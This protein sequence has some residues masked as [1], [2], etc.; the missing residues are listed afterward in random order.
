MLLPR[1]QR[2]QQTRVLKWAHWPTLL[3][4][5]FLAQIQGPNGLG[6]FLTHEEFSHH[7]HFS[8]AIDTPVAS[9]PHSLLGE[10]EVRDLC[11]SFSWFKSHLVS[12]HAEQSIQPEGCDFSLSFHWAGTGCREESVLWLPSQ[13]SG[14]ELQRMTTFIWEFDL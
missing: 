8:A 12:V 2:S 10:V 4:R 13:G 9:C 3:C 14:S 5:H 6:F 11:H 7:S 1:E